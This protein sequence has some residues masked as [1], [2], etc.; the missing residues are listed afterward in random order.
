MF[1]GPTAT[2]KTELSKQLARKYFDE[3]KLIQFDM[4]EFSEPH[5][6]ARLIGSPPGYVGSEETSLLL[7]RVSEAKEGVLL[8]D[9]IEKADR[10]V[11]NILLQLMEEG[12]V[13]DSTGHEVDCSKFFVVM[14]SNTGIHELSLQKHVG[15]TSQKG[16]QSGDVLEEIKKG[17]TPEFVNRLDGI[18]PFKGLDENV[19]EDLV[20]MYLSKA[21]EPFKVQGIKVEFTTEVVGYLKDKAYSQEYGVR[22]LKRTIETE[23]VD[24]ILDYLEEQ[25]DP[26]GNYNVDYEGKVTVHKEDKP[27]R[28]PVDS[29][30]GAKLSL[31]EDWPSDRVVDDGSKKELYSLG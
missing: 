6:V 5:T 11:H 20:R 15:F 24:V 16:I 23:V 26:K 12:K 17:F 31:D 9:E 4:S 13:T 29:L 25:T 14:T 3:S 30:T 2:G 8:F 10:K 28:V 22:Y 19:F 1:V 18:I 21:L 7:S 27:K